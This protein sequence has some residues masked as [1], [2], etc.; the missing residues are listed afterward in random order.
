[1]ELS[2]PPH[3]ASVTLPNRPDSVRPAV[4]FMMHTARALAIPQ[5]AA[6]LFE[7]ALTEAVTNAVKHGHSGR[8]DAIIIC[9]VQRSPHQVVFRIS[10]S[11]DGFV[12][13]DSAISGRRPAGKW[14]PLFHAITLVAFPLIYSTYVGL[15]QAAREIVAADPL[16]RE[17]ADH[18]ARDLPIDVGERVLGAC[19]VAHDETLHAQHLRRDL[20]RVGVIVDQ[21]FEQRTR[22]G[23]LLAAISHSP[24][25]IGLG[26]D[27]DTAA[28]VYA[29]RSLEVV[30]RGSITIVDGAGAETDAWDVKGHRPVMI[31]G[32]VLHALPA[33]Y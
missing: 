17:I 28:I 32:V 20:A 10:D 8:D 30:G 13:P 24:S 4:A 33:G 23:R 18:G 12:V 27:E 19:E 6:P 25:L 22:L 15:A 14:H 9:E 7:V 29:D 3:T 16:E 5:A 1:M 21:H 2:V 31:S 26:L 11:G